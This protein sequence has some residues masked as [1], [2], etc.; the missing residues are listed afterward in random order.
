MQRNVIVNDLAAFAVLFSKPSVCHVLVSSFRL[1]F[2][3][4]YS[5]QPTKK[6][7]PKRFVH[8]S[9]QESEN[10]IVKIIRESLELF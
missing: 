10:D 5:H 7:F 8:I 3:F 4:S 9:S 6:A 2:S 1:P